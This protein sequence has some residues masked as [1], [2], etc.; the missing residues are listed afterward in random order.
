M[1]NINCRLKHRLR[2]ERKRGT[3]QKG[4]LA[5]FL[6]LSFFFHTVTSN[7]GAELTMTGHICTISKIWSQKKMK[8][9]RASP[10]K[11]K[12]LSEFEA[13]IHYSRPS[14]FCFGISNKKH[15]WTKTDL[16]KL[17]PWKFAFSSSGD[18]VKI[19]RVSCAQVRFSV[20]GKGI[21]MYFPFP[22]N[23]NQFSLSLSLSLTHSPSQ[24]HFGDWWP[25]IWEPR[26][27]H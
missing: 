22:T 18:L 24:R 26:I 4:S 21:R 6:T 2:K 7:T 9:F 12:K 16:E 23:Q 20:P 11:K 8:V 17:V 5:F 25:E 27:W 1:L 14:L 19:T 3:N 15:V 13:F 10:E